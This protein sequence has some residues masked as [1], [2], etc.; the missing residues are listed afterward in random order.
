MFVGDSLAGGPITLPLELLASHAWLHLQYPIIDP[1]QGFGISLLANQG[2]PVYPPQ[3]IVDLLSP[4]NYSMWIL[5]NLVAIAFGSYLLAAS[6]GQ[7]FFASIAVAGAASLAGVAPPNLNQGML[8]PF[9][10]LPFLLLSIRFVLDPGS[11]YRPQGWLGAITCTTLLALSGFQEVL[12]LMTVVIVVYTIAMAVHFETFRRRRRLFFATALAGGMGLIIGC[13]GLLPSLAAIS[14]GSG[15]NGPG[16]YRLHAPLFWLSTLTVPSLTG[17]AMGAQPQDLGQT[18]WTLGSPVLLAVLVLAVALSLRKGGEAVRWYVWPSAFFVL[19]G[20]LGYADVLHVLG[21]FDVP[22]F[23]SI[24]TIRFLQFAWWIPWC[25]LLGVVISNARLL[26]WPELSGA[27]AVTTA[28][29]LVLVARFRDALVERH[30]STYLKDTDG[31]LVFA[32]VLVLV[33][34]TAAWTVRLVG[35][36]V[37]S[38]AMTAVIL[39]SCIYL[40]P[41]NFFPASAGTA[42]TAFRMPG[43]SLQT[44]TPLVFLGTVQQPTQYFSSQ[45]WG[46]I[47]PDAYQ[48]ITKALFSKAETHGYGPLADGMTFGFASVDPR[49]IAVLRSLGVNILLTRSALSVA[50]FGPI[51][52]CGSPSSEGAP[53][54]LCLLG[55][56]SVTGGSRARRPFAYAIAGASPLVVDTARPIAVPSSRTAIRDLLRHLSPR[57]SGLPPYQYLTS[58]RRDLMPSTK[59]EGMARTATT[60]SIELSLRS[61]TSG[62]AVLREAYSPGMHANVNGRSVA[63]MSVDGGLWTA[64]TLERGMNHVELDYATTS[65]LIEFAVGLAGMLSLVVAWSSLTLTAVWKRRSPKPLNA[66]GSAP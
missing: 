16:A 24:V 30:V 43:T 59:V 27:L 8:N 52:R 57:S 34:L 38:G 58:A 50:V 60:E 25:L 32:L 46:P 22:L 10:L 48:K 26:K 66:K 41:T 23:T 45:I 12:P 15:V 5:V 49:L 54:V 29:D 28:F 42:V 44:R 17:G 63:A 2:V 55:R 33:F 19:F 9:A 13:V 20:I 51:S 53:K 7:C 47:I 21:I 35:P 40:V 64:I 6:F 61:E 31:A 11:R 62:L 18:V 39:G 14:A 1:Y 4:H 3:L 56:A 37:A 36:T 65:D